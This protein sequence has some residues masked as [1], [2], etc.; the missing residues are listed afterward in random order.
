MCRVAI[1]A[2]AKAPHDLEFVLADIRPELVEPLAGKLGTRAKVQ[3]LDLYD[4]DALR[5][6]IAGSSLV[7]LGAGP[8]VRT[9]APVIEACLELKIP[10]L[11]YDEDVEST[12]HALALDARAKEAGIPMYVG[13]GA[14]PG[15]SNVMA[16]LLYTSDAAD[17]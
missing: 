14:S 11:D 6:T 4:A 17:E 5:A 12:E 2:L 8:Y 13:C 3:K 7:I 15:M 16:C 1:E 9:S 10:Y